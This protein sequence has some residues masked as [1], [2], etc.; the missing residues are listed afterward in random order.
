MDIIE[1][2]KFGMTFYEFNGHTYDTRRGAEDAKRAYEARLAKNVEEA[3]K[4]V[5]K[6]NAA[7]DKAKTDAGITEEPQADSEPV[8]ETPKEETFDIT[9]L[10]DDDLVA[11]RNEST[12]DDRKAF[13]DE[14]NKRNSDGQIH[15]W[16]AADKALAEQRAKAEEAKASKI[17]SEITPINGALLN[18]N[19]HLDELL[20]AMDKI[21]LCFKNVGL[22]FEELQKKSMYFN[23]TLSSGYKNLAELFN[24]SKPTY[25]HYN[26]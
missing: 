20:A 8:I 9:T 2:K 6:A 21:S 3:Q 5:D 1:K 15:S 25:I 10:S 23:D 17:K 22:S 11:K 13:Q 24:L 7:L 16:Q 12:G 26:I 14:I 19:T 18:L 4:K